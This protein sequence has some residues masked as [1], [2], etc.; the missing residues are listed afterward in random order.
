MD[1]KPIANRLSAALVLTAF[2]AG[3]AHAETLTA[4]AAARLALERPENAALL[5]AD[6][7]AARGDLV[8]ARTW[9]N[10]VFS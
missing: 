8:S 7:A 10:P 6:V 2:S 3:A 5:T 1:K 4:D 9:R